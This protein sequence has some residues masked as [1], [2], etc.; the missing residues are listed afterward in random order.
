MRTSKKRLCPVHDEPHIARQRARQPRRV[1]EDRLPI[2]MHG[3]LLREQVICRTK[4]SLGH[5][6]VGSC[7]EF[8]WRWS[9]MST[10]PQIVTIFLCNGLRI[11]SKRIFRR[12]ALERCE[13][14]NP[15]TTQQLEQNIFSSGDEC[16]AFQN[17][18]ENLLLEEEVLPT[19]FHL[20]TGYRLQNEP[21]P[22]RTASRLEIEICSVSFF[23]LFCCLSP[24]KSDRTSIFRC[25]VVMQRWSR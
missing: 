15:R 8:S 1:P 23:V 21:P 17:R 9:G 22:P 12:A 25:T 4:V 5:G 14:L 10:V 6:Q 20:S 3:T 16:R 11:K 7:F 13:V 24:S 19:V 18:P 2:R